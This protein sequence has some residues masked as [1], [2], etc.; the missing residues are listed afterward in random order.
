MSIT[1][2]IRYGAADLKLDYNRNLALALA[3]SV[4]V[5]VAAIGLFVM[6]ADPARALSERDVRADTTAPQTI[7]LT[8]V[9]E[10][11]LPPLPVPPSL[12]DPLG[13]GGG[14]QTQSASTF[15]KP[16]ITPLEEVVIDKPIATT[17]ELPHVGGTSGAYSDTARGSGG[18]GN[19]GN[20]KGDP[21]GDPN[22]RTDVIAEP[23]DLSK[24][25]HSEVEYPEYS[26]S[27]LSRHLEYPRMA[28]QNGIEGTVT[29]K[30]LV[31]VD[32]R[33]RRVD[34]VES[35]SALFDAAAI[36]AV[37]STRFTPARQNNVPVPVFIT[38]D[39][40]FRLD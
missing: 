22:A 11:P 5:H 24:D 40:K 13:G 30:V 18:T 8:N 1:E 27:E 21:N 12:G 26:G 28:R 25:F 4:V 32:G 35:T 34:V 14:T 15:G 9:I 16:T 2:R 3:I 37:R 7:E 29:V 10:E 17:E 19:S 20:P 31:D 39:I 6:S 23:M 38:F 33:A 36:Y